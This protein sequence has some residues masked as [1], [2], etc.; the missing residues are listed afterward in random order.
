MDI[1]TSPSGPDYLA[2]TYI[3]IFCNTSGGSGLYTYTWRVYCSSTGI[4]M[5]ESVFDS[6]DSLRVKST[7]SLCFDMVECVVRD[8]ALPLAGSAS[9][10]ITSV[11]G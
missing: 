10:I 5:Y 4:L 2:A 8:T 1:Y 3:T 9:L 7:P 6:S 11:V